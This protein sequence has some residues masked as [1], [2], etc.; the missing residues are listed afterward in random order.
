MFSG[1][2]YRVIFDPVEASRLLTERNLSASGD[3]MH[4]LSCRSQSKPAGG[5]GPGNGGEQLGGRQTT[6]AKIDSAHRSRLARARGGLS[7]A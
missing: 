7:R 1:N 6:A 5:F 2:S 3:I 4:D